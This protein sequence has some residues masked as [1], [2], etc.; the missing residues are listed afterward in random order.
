M[1]DGNSEASCLR[2]ECRW[3]LNL[4]LLRPPVWGRDI[5]G[6]WGFR[7]LLPEEGDHLSG[8]RLRMDAK[9]AKQWN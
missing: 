7:G 3:L 9:H 5:G 4:D 6:Y 2:E 1:A 8:H